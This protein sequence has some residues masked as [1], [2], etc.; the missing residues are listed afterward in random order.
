VDELSRFVVWD[1]D[2]RGFMI[3]IKVHEK[4]VAFLSFRLMED[5][6]GYCLLFVVVFCF[7]CF[8]VFGFL[9]FIGCCFFKSL[10]VVYWIFSWF[11]KPK[12]L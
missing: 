7:C 6:V 3:P 11:C 10:F 9:L 12:G 4:Y 5:N 1:D 8:V 2:S